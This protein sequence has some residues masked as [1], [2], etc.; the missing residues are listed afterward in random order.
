MFRKRKITLLEEQMVNAKIDIGV[1]IGKYVFQKLLSNGYFDTE[2]VIR[3]TGSGG[4]ANSVYINQSNRP[5]RNDA[6]VVWLASAFPSSLDQRGLNP[7]L[8]KIRMTRGSVRDGY[9]SKYDLKG[10]LMVEHV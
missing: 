6:V 5:H 3:M 1:G 9:I 2:L 4:H 10:K 7:F 8:W